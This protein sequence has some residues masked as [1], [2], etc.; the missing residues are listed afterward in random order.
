MQ[1][2]MRIGSINNMF[3][4]FTQVIDY[5][6]KALMLS[7]E[8]N[9]GIQEFELLRACLNFSIKHRKCVSSFRENNYF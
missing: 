2:Y 9:N 5:Y 3:E 1:A 6:E 8:T 7:R 4:D